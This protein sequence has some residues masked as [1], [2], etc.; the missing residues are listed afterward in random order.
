MCGITGIISKKGALTDQAIQMVLEM[1]NQMHH[2]GPDSSG[3]FSDTT[4]ALAM[5][6]LSIIDLAGGDQPIYNETE[7]ILVFQNGEIYNYQELRQKLVSKGHRFKTQSDTEVLVHLYEEYGEAMCAHLKG[8][9]AFCLYDKVRQVVLLARDRFGEK[10]LYY[11]ESEDELIFAS[12]LR[13]LLTYTKIP[14][15]LNREALFYYLRTSLLPEPITLFEGVHI[16]PAGHL[17]KLEGGQLSQSAYFQIEYPKPPIK[18][19]S[20]ARSLVEPALKAAVSR[21]MVSDV[22][23]GAF[24]SGGIDSSTMVALMQQTS[25]RPIQTF[26]VRF[27]DQAYDESPIARLVAQRC[28]TDHHEITVPNEQFTEDIFWSIIEHMGQPFRDSSAIPTYLVSKAIGDHVKVAI[29]GD[30]GDELFGGY[31]VFQWY[32][33]INSLKA[34]P[35]SVLSLMRGAS[36]LLQKTPGFSGSSKVRQSNRAINSAFLSEADMAIALNEMFSSGEIEDLLA[37]FGPIDDTTFNLLKKYPESSKAWSALR[38]IMYY[39][40]KHTLPANMLVKVD[41]MS[42]AHS[43]EVRAPFLDPDLASVASRLSDDLLV[44]KGQGKYVIREIMKDH[45]PA[46][47]FNHPKQGFNIPLHKYQNEA[48]RKL[49]HTLLFDDNPFPGLLKAEELERLYHQGLDTKEDSSRISAF[50]ASHQLW[51]IMQLMGWAKR[52]KVNLN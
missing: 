19:I 15:N 41:R 32:T 9:F 22:P 24:L 7:E 51:M 46:E 29:S 48:Y 4:C 18:D 47:V 6:R 40:M 34:L 33:R 37:G 42:M 8:M 45:L 3:S 17:L 25:S 16:L 38:Q 14:R 12:E 28:G 52:F 39:R 26:N 10:P 2:R 1:N 50:R 49:A 11:Y 35:S 20:E 5:K 43:L 23:L 31:D 36:G 44:H 13:A 27:E 21:Q 30:G